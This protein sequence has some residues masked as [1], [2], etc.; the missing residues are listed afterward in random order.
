MRRRVRDGAVP[1]FLY[2]FTYCFDKLVKQFRFYWF[3]PKKLTSIGGQKPVF[4]IQ[5]DVRRRSHHE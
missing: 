3:S 2:G 1:Y 5:K 4:F